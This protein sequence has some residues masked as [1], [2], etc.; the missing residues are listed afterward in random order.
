MLFTVMILLMGALFGPVPSQE[1]ENPD[2][3]PI[4]WQFSGTTTMGDKLYLDPASATR[5]GDV[6]TYTEKTVYGSSL[7][8]TFTG[9]FGRPIFSDTGK[10]QIDCANKTLQRLQFKPA[11]IE[12]DSPME[13]LMTDLCKTVKE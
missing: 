4:N 3:P 8:A 6:I 13:K 1:V 11:P 9:M 10:A 12:P 5:E 7:R 2:V